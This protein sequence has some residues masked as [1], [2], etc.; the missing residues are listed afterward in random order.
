MLS[1]KFQVID[2]NNDY[3]LED[4]NQEIRIIEEDINDLHDITHQLNQMIEDQGNDLDRVE[5]NLEKSKSNIKKS[6]EG[7]KKSA[8][9]KKNNTKCWLKITT[10]ITILTIGILIIIL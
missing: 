1:P 7:I 5:N 2:Y 10:F 9:R 4:R 3:W 6:T 8:N